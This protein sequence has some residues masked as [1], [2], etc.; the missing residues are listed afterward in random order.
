MRTRSAD[1]TAVAFTRS[2]RAPGTGATAYMPQLNGLRAFAAL[3]VL[4]QHTV[5]YRYFRFGINGVGIW[6][7]WLFF[8][9]S[10]FLITGILLRARGERHTLGTTLRRFYVRRSLRIFPLY[11][12]VLIAGVAFGI[13]TSFRNDFFWHALYLNNWSVVFGTS[14]I[15]PPAGPLWSLSIEEQ[16]YLVWPL[17]VLSI[18]VRRL[19]ALFVGTAAVGILSRFVLALLLPP[20]GNPSGVFSVVMPTTSNLDPLAWGALLA[21]ARWGAIPTAT[22]RRWLRAALALGLVLL[23]CV[24]VSTATTLGSRAELVFE[25]VAAGLLSV[26]LIDRAATGF[27]RESVAARILSFPAVAYVGTISYGVYV[28]HSPVIWVL[29]TQLG[30]DLGPRVSIAAALG[31]WLLVTA[32]TIAVASISWFAF[33]R[34]INGLKDRLTG[35]PRRTRPPLREPQAA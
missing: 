28:L 10:G 18:P 15:D 34:P 22:V 9:L 32:V 1:T 16:F 7:V 2:E 27:P 26:W 21:W 35:P 24:V 14:H 12:A 17:L 5:T 29:H 20:V 3:V 23:A 25:P 4:A 31:Y 30:W 33:E 13:G 19:G 11:Y 8:V 6:G